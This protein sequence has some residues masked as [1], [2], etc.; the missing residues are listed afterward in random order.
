MP[1]LFNIEAEVHMPLDK[2]F[3]VKVSD[4]VLGIFINGMVV[5]PPDGEHDWAVYP[6]NQRNK[7]GK[8]IPIVQF[9]TH[10]PLW[11]EIFEACVDQVKLYIADSKDVVVTDIPDGPITL[12]DIPDF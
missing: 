8:Y 12:D 9:N 6:P 3:R 7:F 1:K 5:F 11:E 2:G 10:L 4:K